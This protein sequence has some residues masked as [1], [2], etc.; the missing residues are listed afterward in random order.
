MPEQTFEVF[1]D[2][3]HRRRLK[4]PRQLTLILRE[5]ALHDQKWNRMAHLLNSFTAHPN[6][7]RRLSNT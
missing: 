4:V 6:R 2:T 1:P 3:Q 5:F 7:V